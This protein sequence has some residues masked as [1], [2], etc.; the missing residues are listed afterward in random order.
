[1]TSGRRKGESL[2]EANKGVLRNPNGEWTDVTADDAPPQRCGGEDLSRGRNRL[3]WRARQQRR[4]VQPGTEKCRMSRTEDEG[5]RIA[6]EDKECRMEWTMENGGRDCG[7]MDGR[8]GGL[9]MEIESGQDR[10]IEG[11][12]C[13][14]RF[15]GLR[16]EGGKRRMEAERCELRTEGGEPRVD[17]RRRQRAKG[18]CLRS[19]LLIAFAFPRRRPHPSPCK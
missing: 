1:M 12:Y 4:S 3:C 17:A 18:R 16:K 9:C 11:E 14:F 13:N 2:R 7:E 6:M 5:W 15:G 19:R 10:G 8:N